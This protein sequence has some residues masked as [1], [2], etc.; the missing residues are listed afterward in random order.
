MYANKEKIQNLIDKQRR[1]L[2]EVDYLDLN[3]AAK[4]VKDF[5]SPKLSDEKI[6]EIYPEYV[7]AGD[8]TAEELGGVKVIWEQQTLDP[9]TKGWVLHVEAG[10]WHAAPTMTIHL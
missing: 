6:R 5:E 8:A 9:S 3:S 4:I 2:A 10:T 7:E 1:T